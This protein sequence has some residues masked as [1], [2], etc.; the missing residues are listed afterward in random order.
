MEINGNL[1]LLDYINIGDLYGI[2][3]MYENRIENVMK[4]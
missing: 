1:R 3:D 4:I 2:I